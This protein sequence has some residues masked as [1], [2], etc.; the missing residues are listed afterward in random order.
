MITLGVEEEYFLLDPDTGLPAPRVDA[1]RAAAG[2][3]PAAGRHEVQEE[4]L[5]AQIEVAT[6]VCLRLD[7]VAGHLLRLRYAVSAAA[8][9]AGCVLAASGTPPMAPAEPVPVSGAPRA[10]ATRERAAQ[11]ADEQLINGMHVHV[12]VPDRPTGVAVLNRIRPWLPVLVAMAGNSPLWH[13]KDTGFA[14]WRTIVFDRWPVSGPPPVFAG[15]ADYETRIRDLVESTVLDRGQVYW[16]ARLSDRYPT[17]EVRALDVQLRVD[18]TVLFAGLIRALV[19]TALREHAGSVPYRSMPQELLQVANWHAARYGLT[20]T[21]IGT[22]GVARPA[23]EVVS[24]LVDHLTPAL[25]AAGDTRQ[26][27][28]L[29]RRLL[30]EGGPAQRQSRAFA[31]DGVKGVVRLITDQTVA[32][33]R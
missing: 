5:Q 19:V 16:Q 32:V 4:L 6:P 2:L 30:A 21:L 27:L 23:R 9:R 12:A 8:E 31:R 25:D 20:D 26:V 18:E 11:L 15:A 29:V 3:E 24:G 14:S 13:E 7:E 28:P 1:V 22:E 17:L 10:G 33:E